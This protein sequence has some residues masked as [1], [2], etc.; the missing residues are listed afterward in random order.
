[1]KLSILI[2][3]YNERVVVERSLAQ[4]LA[5]RD[6]V[7]LLAGVAGRH[8]GERQTFGGEANLAG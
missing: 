8:D 1:M 2:P 6:I 4:V 7:D 3:V 5:A